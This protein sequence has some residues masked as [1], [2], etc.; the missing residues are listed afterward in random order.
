MRRVIAA[1]VRCVDGLCAVVGKLAMYLVFLMIGVLMY[2]CVTRTV[3]NLPLIWSVEFS[4]FVMSAYYLLGG[5]YVVLL[6]G[7]V[8]M[9]LFYDRWPPR[10]QAMVDVVTDFC[11]IS[12]LVILFIGGVLS[13]DYALQYNQTARS[14]WAPPMAPIK[15]IMGVGVALMLLQ[16]VSILFKDV[17]KA[18]GKPLA[19]EVSPDTSSTELKDPAKAT[20]KPLHE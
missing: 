4:Q 10:R 19:V 5:A 15:I 8:R 11:L 9:D 12:Y 13:I 20:R 18:L 17:A 1:Y 6:K 14:A 16:S 7:H 3:F 2:S